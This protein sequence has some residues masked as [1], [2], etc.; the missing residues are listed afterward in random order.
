M[1]RDSI[2]MLSRNFQDQSKQ[3]QCN[4][5]S[6]LFD[7]YL[8]CSLQWSG[9]VENIQGLVENH[10]KSGKYYPDDNRDSIIVGHDL[11]VSQF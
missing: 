5:L 6:L 1:I 7:F 3:F 10:L 4:C 9:L 11:I 2:L 8:N